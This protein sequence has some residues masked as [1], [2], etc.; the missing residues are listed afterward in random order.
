MKHLAVALGGARRSLTDEVDEEF[1]GPI[2]IGIDYIN[3]AY[4]TSLMVGAR[5]VEDDEVGDFEV[6][7][8]GDFVY[9]NGMYY[10]DV[11]VFLYDDQDADDVATYGPRLQHYWHPDLA[12][13][14][15]LGIPA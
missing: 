15:A 4:F 11:T 7:H 14:R 3:L 13:L 8:Q 1:Q 5:R 6:P 12:E 9:Y 10:S 2:F